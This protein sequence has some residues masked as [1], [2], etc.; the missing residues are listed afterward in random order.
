MLGNRCYGK[1]ELTKYPRSQ[2]EGATGL[3]SGEFLQAMQSHNNKFHF[4]DPTKII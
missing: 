3:F 4:Y 1:S 2:S